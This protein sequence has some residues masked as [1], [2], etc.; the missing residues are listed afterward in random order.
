MP[1]IQTKNLTKHYD[2]IKAVDDLSI[3]VNEGEIF[4]LLGPNGAGKTTLLMM[5]T[6]L[7]KPTSGSALV[8]DFDIIK[9]PAKVRNSIGI[10]FQDPSSDDLL[11]GYENLKLHGLLY[12][13]PKELIQKRINEVLNLVDLENRKNDRIEKY[14][15]GMRRRLEI[16]RGLMHRP[17]ILFLDEPT[18][19]LDP[20]S[21]EKIWEYIEK[22]AKEEKMT[23]I[24]TTHYM[25]EAEKL[26]DKIAIIDY[27]KIVALDTTE[28]LKKIIGGDIVK[29]K[30]GDDNDIE[31]IKKLKYVK[32]VQCIDSELVLTIS[33]SRE[34]LSKLLKILKDVETV[35][36]RTA[37]LNDVFLHFTGREIRAETPE[38][39]WMQR[40]ASFRS[41]R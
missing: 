12:G 2:K 26:C 34:N 11:T 14:S 36:V 33:N 32:K 28:N 25:E 16:A 8:N 30:V 41:R 21:R 7:L 10:V 39:G 17:K 3:E 5:L 9:Q 35:E 23:I 20:A 29:L 13:M 19:G 4:G 22:M 6:T 37:S 18:L 27:G 38:G 31:K 15:G 1:I 40:I 24:L